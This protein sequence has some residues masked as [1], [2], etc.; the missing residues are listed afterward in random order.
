MAPPFA[1]MTQIR[2]NGYDLSPALGHPGQVG[3]FQDGRLEVKWWR[4]F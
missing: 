4:L 3:G 1:G 2:F